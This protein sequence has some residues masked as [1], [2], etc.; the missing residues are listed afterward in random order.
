MTG[1]Q[2]PPENSGETSSD[3]ESTTSVAKVSVSSLPNLK[4]EEVRNRAFKRATRGVAE[5]EV[6]NFLHRVA[7]ELDAGR[8]REQALEHR[9]DTLEA[10]IANPP[11][12]TEEVLLDAFG[13]E[14]ARVLRTAQEAAREIRAAAEDKSARVIAEAETRARGLHDE[15]EAFLAQ[16]REE[17]QELAQR[18]RS[19]AEEVAKQ[20]DVDARAHASE[21]REVAETEAQATKTEALE[22]AR[23]MVAEAKAVRERV[24]ADLA[25]RRNALQGQL[26]ELRNGRER[27][28]EGY[29]VVRRTLADAT[30]ALGGEAPEPDIDL[31]ALATDE[32]DFEDPDLD[33]LLE[34]A[35]ESASATVDV[36]P[37]HTV[38]AEANAPETPPPTDGAS[39]P[40]PASAAQVAV[41]PSPAE[42]P[43][44]DEKAVPQ[45]SGLR[46][47]VKGALG[48]G[49]DAD[50]DVP[51]E[52]VGE[53]AV[54]DDDAVEGPAADAT[55]DADGSDSTTRDPQSVFAKLRA[56]DDAA[57]SAG[58]ETATDTR[59][60]DDDAGDVDGEP[61]PTGDA[62]LLAQRD[63][64]L[65][66]AESKI[67]KAVKREAQN[68]Q[69]ELLDA[70][71]RAKRRKD[72]TPLVPEF[73]A[74][75]ESWSGVVRDPLSEAYGG[76]APDE[77]VRELT[78]TLLGSLHERLVDAI[79]EGGDN[80]G[81]TQRVGARFRE[82]RSQE[83]SAAVSAVAAGAHARG[84]YDR[85]ASGSRLR[86]VAARP[87]R[88]PDCDDN[89]LEATL[90]G[91]DFPTGQAFPPAHPGC[92]CLLVLE[93]TEASR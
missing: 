37:G 88:C 82:W 76:D 54:V 58:A 45:G 75:I 21:V 15:G 84:V 1:P 12:V 35:R 28:L 24:L 86:W 36:T 5:A 73:D 9:I 90:R 85:A 80:E 46:G 19:D 87:G 44:P 65:A 33:R 64:H 41:E 27:L 30:R 7:E 50:S 89:A 6:R 74:I 2:A 56:D 60:S 39:R 48:L 62:A 83:L 17:G 23:A 77:L 53:E 47:Y 49:K 31:A 8:A 92:R 81:L 16:R 14:T 4:S 3:T 68:D 93:D 10:Q 79:A 55:E 42:A 59:E 13:D 43:V 32:P 61:A 67:A 71:R 34:E 69:N 38:E 78:T 11:P 20:L 29:Q 57:T 70:I 26:E 72:L 91:E 63:D 66:P 51:T 22:Q 40:P 52:V 18:L 25:R